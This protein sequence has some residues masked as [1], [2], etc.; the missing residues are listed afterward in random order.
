MF[1]WDISDEVPNIA[2]NIGFSTEKRFYENPEVAKI[3]IWRDGDIVEQGTE[4]NPI[5]NFQPISDNTVERVQQE[6]IEDILS[7]DPATAAEIADAIT[8]IAEDIIEHPR[9]YTMYVKLIYEVFR[10]YYPRDSTQNGGTRQNLMRP[11]DLVM[12]SLGTL[13]DQENYHNKTKT[14]IKN[15]SDNDE[16]SDE[17][18]TVVITGWNYDEKCTDIH[19]FGAD[20][21]VTEGGTLLYKNGPE[22][23]D[24]YQ[25]KKLY[26]SE[27]QRRTQESVAAVI[28]SALDVI[29]DPV[30]YSQGNEVGACMYINPPSETLSDEDNEGLDEIADQ[31]ASDIN[32]RVCEN[33]IPT[34]TSLK[35]GLIKNSCESIYEF[36]RINAKK[37]SFRPYR[38]QRV[39][40]EKEILEFELLAPNEV[41]GKYDPV[42]ETSSET[43]TEQISDIENAA[44]GSS[45]LVDAQYVEAQSDYCIDVFVQTKK[46]AYK[47]G[48]LLE[49]LGYEQDKPDILYVSKG[50]GSDRSLI[51]AIGSDADAEDS[52]FRFQAHAVGSGAPER[53]TTSD[54]VSEHQDVDSVPRLIEKLV[55]NH[56]HVLDPISDWS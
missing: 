10:R 18:E 2:E 20:Y 38:L 55:K 9:E 28:R 47:K 32:D 56:D 19:Q 14:G 53:L 4:R 46:E 34:A 11:F 39:D 5:W 31:I 17:V 29:D 7:C 16:F 52:N 54:Y 15:L 48:S 22:G 8:P 23:F 13:D 27:E 21:A 33:E 36:E 42:E 30:F 44:I 45:E 3:E 6:Q 37:R 24:P 40:G 41:E 51:D 50:T 49:E 26:S 12:T 43:I 35:N 25:S 1:E